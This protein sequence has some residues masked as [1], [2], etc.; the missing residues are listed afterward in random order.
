MLEFCT[1]HVTDCPHHPMTRKDDNCTACIEKNLREQE[2][3][4]CFHNMI[5]VQSD[6]KS[7]TPY[8]FYHFAKKV[9]EVEGEDGPS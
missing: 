4:T 5:G 6:E 1:C 9:F 2:I 8:S 3:P 7:T